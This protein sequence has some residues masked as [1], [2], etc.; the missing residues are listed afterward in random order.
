MTPG[1]QTLR[2]PLRLGD[3]IKVVLTTLICAVLLKSF[4]VEA[5]RI[6]SGSMENTLMAGDMILVDKL[7]YGLRTPSSLPFF[8][9]IFTPGYLLS[10]D[11]VRRG[12]VIVFEFIDHDSAFGNRSRISLVKR[13]IGIPGDTIEIRRSRVFVNGKELLEPETVRPPQ[14]EHTLMKADLFPDGYGFTEWEYGP[15]RVPREG[16]TIRLNADLVGEWRGILERE[17]HRVDQVDAGGFLI[18]GFVRETYVLENDYYFVL[19]DHRENSVDSRMWGFVC[20]EDIVGEALIVYWSDAATPEWT[21]NADASKPRI[22]W[23]RV[24]TLVR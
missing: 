10:L 16:D 3:V 14:F 6:P 12:D 5:Y 4:V 15:L 7:A 23:E 21:F 2:A 18:D 9:G 22:R 19:G 1:G 11:N 20:E 13:C 8:P 24:G 17:G